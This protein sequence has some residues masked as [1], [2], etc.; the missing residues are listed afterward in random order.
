MKGDF[1]MLTSTERIKLEKC[2]VRDGV[3]GGMKEAEGSRLSRPFTWCLGLRARAAVGWAVRD[4]L[5][6]HW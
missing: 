5:L 4:C 3:R 1:S 2:A 6:H